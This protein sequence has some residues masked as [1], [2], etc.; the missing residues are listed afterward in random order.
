MPGNPRVHLVDT[1]DASITPTN[2]LP[3]VGSLTVVVG[4][5]GVATETAQVVVNPATATQLA[6]TA[7]SRQSVA[8]TNDGANALY[9]GLSSVMTTITTASNVVFPGST[10][11]IDSQQALFGIAAAAATVT[12]RVFD[13]RLS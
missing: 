11:W 5:G 1:N 8:I 13:T 12:A 2:P 4:A 10:H 7:S 6:P 9:I 3:V